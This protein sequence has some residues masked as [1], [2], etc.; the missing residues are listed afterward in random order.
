MR[1]GRNNIGYIDGLGSGFQLVGMVSD[2]IPPPALSKSEGLALLP[3]C[4]SCSACI[5]ECSRGAIERGRFLLHAE[6]CYT[7]FSESPKPIPEDV[8]PPSPECLVGCM[9]CQ[10]VCPENKGRLHYVHASISFSSEETEAFLGRSGVPS[11]RKAAEVKFASLD[12]SGDQLIY[13][14]NL[15]RMLGLDS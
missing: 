5:E 6:E 3:R 8:K 12:L 13:V 15:N 14:R 11:A 7:L 1:D 2:R 4:R 10:D 9:K